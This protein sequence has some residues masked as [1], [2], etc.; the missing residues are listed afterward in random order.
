MTSNSNA[1]PT[2]AFLGLGL[3]GAPMARRLTGAGFGLSVWNRS[4]AKAASFAGPGFR[5]NLAASAY[6]REAG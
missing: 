6:C 5:A 4:A 2:V 3:M 1:N